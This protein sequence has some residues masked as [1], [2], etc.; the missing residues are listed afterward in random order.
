MLDGVGVP[1]PWGIVPL[2]R[3]WQRVNVTQPAAGVDWSAQVPGGVLWVV[4]GFRA[5]LTTAVA[6]GNRRARLSIGDGA[7]EL[8]AQAQISVDVTASLVA[9]FGGLL[10]GVPGRVAAATLAT[11]GLP[12]IYLQPGWT[13]GISTENLQA[14]DQWSAVRLWVAEYQLRGLERAAERYAAAIADA[15]PAG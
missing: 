7:D 5:T 13:F 4:Q 6:V 11:C 3:L 10:G 14:A 1:L 8:G 12:F 15:V 2:E 9:T